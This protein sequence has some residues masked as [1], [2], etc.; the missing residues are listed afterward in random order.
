MP[1]SYILL[2]AA[3][4]A[5]GVPQSV[6]SGLVTRWAWQALLVLALVA[7]LAEGQM[8]WVGTVPVILLWATA[9][10]YE[11]ASSSPRRAACEMG[12]AL[13]AIAMA[14]HRLPG[15]IPLIIADTQLSPASVPMTL[16]AHLDK[17]MAGLILLAVFTR[18][19]TTISAIGRSFVI[20]LCVGLTTAAI[21]VGAV[22]LLGAVRLDPKLPAIALQWMAVN[23]FL[24][25]VLEEALF[26]GLLQD[27]L[28]GKLAR[29]PR[30]EWIAVAVASLLFGLVHA[31]GGPLLMLAAAAA[32]IG[33]GTAYMLARRIEA[34]LFAHFTLNT[35]HFL[36]FTYPYGAS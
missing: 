36:G 16:R 21:V 8:T 15:F 7:A 18:R 31:G 28:A 35:V 23:L 11:R 6:A 25:C 26:R 13:M 27:R 24:T 20:G 14:T 1:I 29:R 10:G 5:T 3:I 33:Y 22:A 2:G 4:L 30:S 32:G 9:V 12:A 17:G 34:A 19:S